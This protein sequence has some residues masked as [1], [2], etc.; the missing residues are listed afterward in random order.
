MTATALQ[1]L[2][3]R[4][5]RLLKSPSPLVRSAGETCL[6]RARRF[7]ATHQPFDIEL[8]CACCTR[9]GRAWLATGVADDFLH[10][11]CC[12]AC[13]AEWR[14]SHQGARVIKRDGRDWEERP[15]T[16]RR[17]A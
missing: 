8:T 10:P 9:P 7:L 16:A 1:E 3:E 2:L 11:L 4:A 17:A 14:T 5:D 13:I 12:G 6:A 15:E